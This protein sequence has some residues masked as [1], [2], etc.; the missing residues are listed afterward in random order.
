MVSHASFPSR[1]VTCRR[2]QVR[3]VLMSEAGETET[4]SNP[5]PSSP[6]LGSRSARDGD[7]DFAADAHASK[8]NRS[9]TLT[10]DDQEGFA[11][12][13]EKIAPLF[14]SSTFPSIPSSSIDGLSESAVAAACAHIVTTRS[15]AFPFHRQFTTDDDVAAMVCRCCLRHS[16][17]LFEL[18]L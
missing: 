13:C 6:S 1:I 12:A 8:K 15:I 5:D 4:P 11:E 16:A 3:A 10:L 18:R 2:S 14:T 9:S 17:N 7:N